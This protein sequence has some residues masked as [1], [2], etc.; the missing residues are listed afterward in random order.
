[1]P[2]S[3]SS[4]PREAAARTVQARQESRRIGPDD[5]WTALEWLVVHRNDDSREW[6]PLTSSTECS[7][8]S[9]AVAVL[10]R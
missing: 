4:K 5:R 2:V 3:S 7:H 8:A 10:R 9:I 1:M 6:H